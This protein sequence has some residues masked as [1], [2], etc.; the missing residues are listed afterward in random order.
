[1]PDDANN[2]AADRGPASIRP[3][4]ILPVIIIT[5]VAG[6]ALALVNEVTKGP[7]AES[8]KQAKAEALSA[9]LPAFANDPTSDRHEVALDLDA[10]PE[11]GGNPLAFYA[12]RDA[13]G[14]L[15][16]WGIE[17][18]VESGYSGY[19]SL[20]FGIDPEGRVQSVQILEQ[21]ETPGLGTK[22]DSQDFLGQYEGKS[23]AD[24]DFNVAKDGGEVDAITGATIS[25]RAVS[26]CVEQGLLEYDARFKGKDP[27]PAAAPEE[28]GSSDGQ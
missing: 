11:A 22:V 3:V 23:L 17:S 16:G 27:G 21:R 26:R 12:G 25:S 6:V 9:V 13:G 5:C 20:V 15:T 7:I 8:K 2:A 18:A 14:A 1:M 28:G 10:Y 19:F 4:L 24:F